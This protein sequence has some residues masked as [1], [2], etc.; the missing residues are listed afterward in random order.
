MPCP[1]CI[2]AACCQNA[3]GSPWSPPGQSSPPPLLSKQKLVSVLL[4]IWLE[5]RRCGHSFEIPGLV[6]FHRRIKMPKDT[7]G[8]WHVLFAVFVESSDFYHLLGA[9]VKAYKVPL[10]LVL[11]LHV[12]S[13]VEA[14]VSSL[15]R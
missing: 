3:R 9:K 14:V 8:T 4:L 6:G 11:L 10:W 2:Q 7:K 12:F 13:E 5:I 1:T 15:C